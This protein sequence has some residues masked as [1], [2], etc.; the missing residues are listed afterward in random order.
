MFFSSFLCVLPDPPPHQADEALDDDPLV[1]ASSRSDDPRELLL[2]VRQLL[3]VAAAELGWLARHP[4]PTAIER[5]RAVTRRVRVLRR[6]TE[7]LRAERLMQ[8]QGLSPE[9]VDGR[10]VIALLVERVVGVA[11]EV[12]PAH[13]AAALSERLR[14]VVARDP[15]IPWP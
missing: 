9:S 11:H 12:M 2:V 14:D 5:A 6:F 8:P 3:A 4:S 13:T 15:G 1:V 7:V 10:H